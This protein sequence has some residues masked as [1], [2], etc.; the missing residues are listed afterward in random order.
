MTWLQAATAAFSAVSSI[1]Q[2][3][4]AKRQAN[5]QA[6]VAEQQAAQSR[7]IAA[8][9]EDEHRRQQARLEAAGRAR[10]GA[11]GATM[12]GTPSL[13]AEELM[14]EGELQALKIR[15]GGDVQ[16]AR[17]QQEAAMMRY[18]GKQAERQGYTRAG[19]SLL[20]GLGS[21]WGGALKSVP[22]TGVEVVNLDRPYTGQ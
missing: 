10:M 11:S 12:S 14:E 21:A 13:L 4:D 7:Q 18:Q 9:Q 19:A 3:Q 20:S 5:Y 15:Y 22:G 16:S 1:Q 8:G 17:A 6:Q 2:G